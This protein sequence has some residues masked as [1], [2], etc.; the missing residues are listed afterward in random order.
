MGRAIDVFDK[1]L[2]WLGEDY[3][4]FCFF[5]ERDIV[6]TLQG[7]VAMLLRDE[8]LSERYKVINDYTVI[9][10]RPRGLSADLAILDRASGGVV[11]AV[12]V[13]Y[14]PS[15]E[16]MDL[17]IPRSKFPRTYWKGLFSV[18]LDIERIKKYVGEGRAR[19]AWA[20]MIDE[21]GH[22]FNKEVDL[23][24]GVWE[25]WG[26]PDSLWPNLSVFKFHQPEVIHYS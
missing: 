10:K 26:K 25:S 3:C 12:E 22:F 24:G 9:K 7:R 18:E 17:D 13:K 6:W 16:R 23:M 19:A 5:V 20:I 1:A 14:E 11:L 15:R 8:K 4:K 2:Q 21:G